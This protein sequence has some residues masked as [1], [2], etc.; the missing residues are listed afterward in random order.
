MT[1]VLALP[2]VDPRTPGPPEPPGPPGPPAPPSAAPSLASPCKLDQ[3][4][5]DE[6]EEEDDAFP[7]SLE[8]FRL[9]GASDGNSAELSM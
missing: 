1:P 2:L 6:E 9:P 4:P 8:I 5:V 7:G 3:R